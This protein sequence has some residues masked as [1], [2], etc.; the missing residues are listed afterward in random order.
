MKMRNISEAE[1]V[2]AINKNDFTESYVEDRIN[3]WKK[4]GDKFIRV[5]YKNE[6]AKIVVI[7]A[8][9]KKKGWR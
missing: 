7:T 2:E 4:S 8:V 5:T 1:V 9:K 3:A 6:S